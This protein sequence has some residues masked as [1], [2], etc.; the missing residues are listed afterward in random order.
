MIATMKMNVSIVMP[1]P[2]VKFLKCQR[3]RAV[4]KK[5]ECTARTKQH[6]PIVNHIRLHTTGCIYIYAY[7]CIRYSIHSMYVLYIDV[8]AGLCN[9]IK[10][11]TLNI[12]VKYLPGCPPSTTLDC[13]AAPICRNFSIF[14]MLYYFHLPSPSWITQDLLDIPAFCTSSGTEANEGDRPHDRHTAK[15]RRPRL[16]RRT[17]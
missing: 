9:D 4:G 6:N 12:L 5:P 7:A 1:F 11:L 3:A 17:S 13:G 15:E 2:S 16:A 10:D 8:V 14:S